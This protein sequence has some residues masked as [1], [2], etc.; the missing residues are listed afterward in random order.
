[1]GIIMTTET[2]S[3]TAE[4]GHKLDAYVAHPDG[5]PK[6]G[7]VVIQEIFGLTEH[8]RAMTE[9]FAA[10]GYLAVAP[11]MFDRVEKN[12]VVDYD[13]FEKAISTMGM[14]DREQSIGDIRAAVEYAKSA[15]KV[16]A[17]GFCWGGSMADL[18]ACNGMVDAGV[19]YY[20]RATVE[21]LDQ[22]PTCPMFYHYGEIDKLISLETIEKI[23]HKRKGNVRIWGGADHGFCCENRPSF[24]KQAAQSSFELTL[25]FFAEHLG[26]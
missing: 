10:E 14:L 18:T 17:I 3:L 6:G 9:K 15:G 1:L 13:D 5:K 25:E 24:H 16:G 26:N 21:W 23:Q 8:I 7:I 19:S 11:A 12:T 4:D 22:Q 2:V 20:G